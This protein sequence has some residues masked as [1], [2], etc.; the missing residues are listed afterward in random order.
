MSNSTRFNFDCS[1]LLRRRFLVL[2]AA[3]MWPRLTWS[4]ERPPVVGVIRGGPRAEDLFERP[5]HE[6]MT[7]RGWEVGRNVQLVVLRLEGHNENLS[8]LINELV[9]LPVDVI[10]VFG[11]AQIQTAQQVSHDIP[12]VGMSEDLLGSGFV[13]SMARPGSNTTGVSLLASELDVKRLEI[14][15]E[16]VPRARRVGVLADPA[17]LSTRPQLE[18]AARNLGVELVVTTAK[19]RDEIRLAIDSMVAARVEAVNVLASPILNQSRTPIMDR[20]RQ[21]RLPAI[22]QWPETAK[23]GGLLAY[24][25]SLV[26]SYRQV[27]GFVDRILKGAKPGDLPIQQPTKFELVINFKTAKALGITIPQSLLQRADDVIK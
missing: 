3:S 15:H 22:Y 2:A 19:D 9:A 20:M 1:L 6:E 18:T 21:T 7:L 12:I 8:A 4:A 13:A 11:D 10:V 5:F 27:A 24:G 25:P 16:F 23:E 14:L 17:T 26:A